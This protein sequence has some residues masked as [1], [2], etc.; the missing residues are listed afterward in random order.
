MPGATHD[1]TDL[2]VVLLVAVSVDGRQVVT[3]T[4]PLLPRALAPAPHRPRVASVIAVIAP[5]GPWPASASVNL[6]EDVTE[7]TS[8]R[9]RLA[10]LTSADVARTLRL[11]RDLTSVTSLELQHAV[12][13]TRN[14][15]TLDFD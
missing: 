10:P 15:G 14:W 12:V 11:T 2:D 4:R 8:S 3:D 9:P 6:V 5:P 7:L 13:F 1:A